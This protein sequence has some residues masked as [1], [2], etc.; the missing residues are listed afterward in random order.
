M[1]NAIL[2]PFFGEPREEAVL[3]PVIPIKSVRTGGKKVKPVSVKT[4]TDKAV[5][6]FTEPVFRPK[7]HDLF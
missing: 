5:P 4:A 6:A 7:K 2:R 1:K 3:A